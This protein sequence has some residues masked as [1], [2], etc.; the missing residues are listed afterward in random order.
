MKVGLS[1]GHGRILWSNSKS[2]AVEGD[3]DIMS[4]V[5]ELGSGLDFV[6]KLCSLCRERHL[7]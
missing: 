5:S 6:F 4:Q 2:P 1:I 3:I 7:I